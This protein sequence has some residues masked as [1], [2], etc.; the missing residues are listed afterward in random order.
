M[1]GLARALVAG[2]PAD[3]CQ[4][5]L[6]QKKATIDKLPFIDA[7]LAGGGVNARELACFARKPLAIR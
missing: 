3:A 7:V 1:S 6:L 4:A 5:D 2:R